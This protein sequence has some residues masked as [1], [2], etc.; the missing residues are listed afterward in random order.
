MIETLSLFDRKIF[1]VI[2]SWNT[3]WL[4]PIM[5]FF[6]SKIVWIPFIGIGVFYSYKKMEKRNFFLFLLF[7]FLAII[8]SDITSSYII[9]NL[10]QRLR[11]CRLSELKPFIYHFGQKCGGKYGFVSS[12][13]AN[14]FS[15]ITYFLT[16]FKI[17]NLRHSLIWILP[18]LVSYSRIYLGVHYPL[19][20][21]GGAMVGIGWGWIMGGLVRNFVLGSK[22]A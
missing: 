2:N 12:H 4:N 9:K 13:A 1:L 15:L 7:F 10:V 16:F 3:I 8:A 17:N 21:I 6:S 20:L 18:F 19:D 14:A 5:I 22:P 11:P